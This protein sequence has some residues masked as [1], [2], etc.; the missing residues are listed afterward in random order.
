MRGYIN[1]LRAKV[2]VSVAGIYPAQYKSNF[3]TEGS[4]GNAQA[5][6][7]VCPYD[8]W[9]FDIVT[10]TKKRCGADMEILFTVAGYYAKWGRTEGI[11]LGGARATRVGG[12]RADKDLGGLV[13]CALEKWS[14][15][16]DDAIENGPVCPEYRVGAIAV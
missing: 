11:C 6:I 14:R 7:D 5:T 12:S 10:S 16:M 9:C 4:S 15:L 2:H 1:A 8:L 3:P 13:R